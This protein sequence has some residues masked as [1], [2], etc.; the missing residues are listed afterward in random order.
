MNNFLQAATPWILFILGLFA[1][2]ISYF[3]KDIRSQLKERMDKQDG[4][5]KEL[6]D[7]LNNFKSAAPTIY[8]LREDFLRS[9]TNLDMKI[10]SMSKTLNDFIKCVSERIGGKAND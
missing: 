2:I 8:V 10:D 3:L 7:D 5:I 6:R 9:V 4:E 1:G